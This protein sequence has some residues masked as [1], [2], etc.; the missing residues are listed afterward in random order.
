PRRR[1]RRG[2][3]RPRDRRSESLVGAVG[4]EPL[5]FARARSLRLRPV[6]RPWP[7]HPL[8]RTI[9]PARMEVARRLAGRSFGTRLLAARAALSPRLR[10]GGASEP[11][12]S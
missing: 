8:P 9:A 12:R 11:D 7:A 1:L 10:P 6:R 4:G 5:A 2:R 3:A